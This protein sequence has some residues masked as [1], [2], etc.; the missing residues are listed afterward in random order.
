MSSHSS[1]RLEHQF[2]IISQ[3][4]VKLS[5]NPT[6]ND[7][8]DFNT[9]GNG[10][11]F[12]DEKSPKSLFFV[13]QSF[14][15]ELGSIG[16]LSISEMSL[17]IV[18]PLGLS[19]VDGIL[20]VLFVFLHGGGLDNQSRIGGDISGVVLGDDEVLGGISDNDGVLEGDQFWM[21]DCTCLRPSRAFSGLVESIFKTKF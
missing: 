14:I 11:F 1:S 20:E 17:G 13:A 9:E 12:E 10:E 21:E 18:V 7:L 3:S 16:V 8:N 4:G 15:V 5:G 2:L 6:G 19:V